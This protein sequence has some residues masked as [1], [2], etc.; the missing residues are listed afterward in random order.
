MATTLSIPR[1]KNVKVKTNA[2]EITRLPDRVLIQYQISFKPEFKGAASERRQKYIE[3]LQILGAND[4][5]QNRMLYDGGAVGFTSFDSAALIGAQ[6]TFYVK[7]KTNAWLNESHFQ[8]KSKD[9]DPCVMIVFE[10]T[11]AVPLQ[12][13]DIA[14]I[15]QSELDAQKRSEALIN[16]LQ[17]IIRQGTNNRFVTRGKAY[18]DMADA[19]RQLVD[20]GRLELRRGIWH[21]ARPADRRLVIMVDTVSTAFYP[22]G[23]LADVMANFLKERDIWRMNKGNRNWSK[24]VKYFQRLRVRVSV[25]EKAKNATKTIKGFESE[26]GLYEFDYDGR[27][28]TVQKYYQVV[29]G[30]HLQYPRAPGVVLKIQGAFKS[31]VPLEF[32][33]LLP[34]QIFK[35]K[36]PE[37]FTREMVKFASVRPTE[38]FK[39]I[40]DAAGIYQ[41]QENMRHMNM[42]VSRQPLVVDGHL[43]PAPTLVYHGAE[44]PSP[45]DGKWNIVG[46][47]FIKPT[48][49]VYWGIINCVPAEV[50]DRQLDELVMRLRKCCESHGMGCQRPAPTQNCPQGSGL[51]QRLSLF[52]Q[53]IVKAN[54]EG[55]RAP[56]GPEAVIKERCVIL[57]ILPNSA[58]DLRAKVKFW[59]DVTTGVQTQ[60]L[61]STGRNGIKRD[62]QYVNNVLLK[63]NARFGGI[64][65]AV[66]SASTYIHLN[67]P[68]NISQKI[69]GGNTIIFGA[70][71]SHPGPGVWS[72]PSIT[73]IV[74]SVDKQGTQYAAITEVQNPRVERIMKLGQMVWRALRWYARNIR[75]P[76]I[77]IVFY[78]DGLSEGEFDTTAQGE[79]QD[80]EEAINMFMKGEDGYSNPATAPPRPK[81]TYIVVGKRH[82]A[83]L[84]PNSELERGPSGRRDMDLDDGKGN[85]K[86]GVAVHEGITQPYRYIADFYLQSHAA[87]QGT[88]RS[89]H[90]IV[91][92]DDIFT[93]WG[94]QRI[95]ALEEY[96]FALCHI[97]AKATRSVSIPAPVYYADLVCQRG[98][99]HVDPEGVSFSF[100]EEASVAGST[101]S[102]DQRANFPISEWEAAFRPVSE[103]VKTKMY[104]L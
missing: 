1:P 49:L 98:A 29:Y 20:R 37:E 17:L 48:G 90:Y 33:E 72:K 24:M 42:Q 46:R 11:V 54:K 50:D 69:I 67:T 15:F 77:N 71:V 22:G 39:Q 21:S 87:I 13:Q 89:S 97:Y 79:I 26:G 104:F 12:P 99:F 25:P 61:R 81:L 74:F 95:Q 60:C 66:G 73:S 47:R 38:R 7:L 68:P 3:H 58:A 44:D 64:N 94:A 59:G 86:A 91:L 55:I 80:I 62:D 78:R 5:F 96:S 45:R 32:C 76:P 34:N 36:I 43:Y 23:R 51:S 52:F 30:I 53:D 4:L 2:F 65:F 19:N 101:T 14:G 8:E 27:P 82:H 31:V 35:S 88:S 57:V 56:E 70:D 16:L 9:R 28:M 75:G 63:I 40:T 85:C 83:L 103:N 100:D 93:R 41:H 102:K 84:F 92:R 6:R 18:Y 10:R